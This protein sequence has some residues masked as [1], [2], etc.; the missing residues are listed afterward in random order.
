MF[1]TRVASFYWL[2]C[3]WVFVSRVSAWWCGWPDSTRGYGLG[4]L[5]LF[6]DL[7]L[8]ILFPER[9]VARLDWVEGWPT[10][11]GLPERCGSEAVSTRLVRPN[12]CFRVCG[13]WEN[14]EFQE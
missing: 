4:L 8:F 6:W 10:S 1:L 11:F 13:N 3:R 12:L 5:G 14:A 2:R 9:F 7:G